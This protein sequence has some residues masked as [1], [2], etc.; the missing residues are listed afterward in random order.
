MKY[1]GKK[2]FKSFRDFKKYVF[3]YRKDMS[4]SKDGTILVAIDYL[5]D[6]DV[7]E[8]IEKFKNDKNIIIDKKWRMAT[9]KGG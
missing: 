1:T 4:V 7:D 2:M 9:I 3:C 8:L 6:N 5:N